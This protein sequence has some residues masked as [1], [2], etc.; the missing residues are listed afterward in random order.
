MRTLS[1]VLLSMALA[2]VA[3]AT[4]TSTTTHGTESTSLNSMISVGD[5]IS[6]KIATEQ[7]GDL[8]WH[9]ANG[10]PLDKLPA[11]TDDAGIR[12]T[13]LTGLLNDFPPSGQPAKLVR[14]DLGGAKNI[15]SIGILTG[16]NGK[17]GRIF[18]TTVI[19]YSIDG[20]TNF[21]VLGYFQS[22][23]SGTLNTAASNPR[24]GS[25][26]VTVFDN[27]SATLLAGVTNIQFDL[28]GVDNTGGQMRDPF[29]GV[30]PF[31][32]LDDGL[33]APNSSPLV[34]E[35]D[36]N[37]VPEPM[38]LGLMALGGLLLARRRR[39]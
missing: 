30:N 33:S 37:P 34:F 3:S 31:T 1:V 9:P 7:P 36:V 16:N 28:Y 6:G 19:R 12:G 21:N 2:S 32:S 4:V 35:L 13:G 38:T 23:P 18:S 22:D 27:A 29:D 14:Y 17:D 11:F 15:G 10:D 26:Y 20:G 25:T 39:A 5:L 8:G 24:N